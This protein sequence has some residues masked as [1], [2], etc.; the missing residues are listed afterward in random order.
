M[1]EV[2]PTSTPLT[3]DQRT[4]KAVLLTFCDPVPAQSLQQL[5]QLSAD[6]WQKLLHWLDTS[7]LALYFLDRMVDLHL[8]HTLPHAVF[9]R[10]KQNLVDNAERTRSLINESFSIQ[11]E[12]QRAGVS[13]ALLKGFSL[14][15]SRCEASPAISVLR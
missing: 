9:A 14:Y 2:K 3:R 5:S 1:S 8:W 4:R 10:L 6:E 11:K 13:Y 15:S 12:F 7:G